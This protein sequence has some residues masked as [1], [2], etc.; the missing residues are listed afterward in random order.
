MATNR[1]SSYTDQTETP[2]NKTIE[3]FLKFW[4]G[5]GE[6]TAAPWQ[7][8]YELTRLYFCRAY[9]KLSNVAVGRS[10]QSSRSQITHDVA[11]VCLM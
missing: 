8:K 1:G 2:A 6:Q 11:Q 3:Y 4:F 5:N 10:T 7:F 9:Q